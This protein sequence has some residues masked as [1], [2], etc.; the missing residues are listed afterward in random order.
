M[1]NEELILAKLEKIEAQLEPMTKSQQ[2]LLELKED[3]V[4]L[5]NTAVKLL[6]QEL[7]EVEAGFQLE[8]LL[9]FV[10]RLVRNI[11]N[12]NW[13]LKQLENIIDFINDL[14]P[15]M[16]S[17]VPQVIAHLDQLE[18]RGVFRIIRA[19]LDIRAKIADAYTPEDIEQIGDGAV[20]VLRLAK[21]FAE[22]K[23]VAFMERLT[24]M[25]SEIDLTQAPKVGPMGLA[26]AG[27]N[28]E[29]K[30]GLGVILELTKA[31]AK[32]KAGNGSDQLKQ[33]QIVEK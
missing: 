3:I 6:I 2:A 1:T 19:M 11:R 9:L 33:P 23:T 27:F 15:L 30:E 32:L 12:L 10:K 22:P 26:A 17:A 29:V 5:G 8:D 25:T 16:K 18:R 4:P 14:E 21:K 7:R 31:M 24:Q 20:N 28:N 13:G